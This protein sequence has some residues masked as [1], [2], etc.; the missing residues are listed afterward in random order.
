MQK[1][2]IV[3][4]TMWRAE[5]IVENIANYIQCDAVSSVV[6]ID[7]D[8]VN[9]ELDK[10]PD[11]PKVRKINHGRNIFVN[12]AWNEGVSFC[13]EDILCI[14]NDDIV[15][16][17]KLFHIVSDLDLLSRQIDLVGLDLAVSGGTSL[18]RVAID[19]AVPLGRQFPGFG[20]CMFLPRA[21]FKAIPDSIKIWF[22]DDYLAHSNNNVYLLTTPLVKGKMSTTI[23][24][25]PP[26]S[27][28]H[29][30]IQ[31]D[32]VWARQNLLSPGST[33]QSPQQSTTTVDLGSG[34]VPR[35][36]FNADRI[37]GVDAHCSGEHILNCWIGFEPLPLADSSVEY[38]TAFDFLEHI[39]RFAMKEKPFNPFIDAMSEIW[40]ILKP[41]GLFFARTPAY[42]S[43]AAFQDPTHVNIITD[44]TVSYFASRP[45]ADGSLIDSWGPP[46]GKRY[47]FK[48]EFVLVKQW[49]DATHLCWHL[50]ATK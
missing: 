6:I 25:F 41:G 16:D 21:R 4:P 23:R 26:D 47:G 42:P 29:G 12:P 50:R 48:G 37:I 38:V 36:P 31:A 2:D 24:S 28:I 10:I 49:W 44:Q 35:N 45:C 46:L 43:A 17:N 1:I 15:V 8:P 5:G 40:R 20:A 9:S 27:E 22:G 34:S 30:V 19:R 11:T 7:N 14:V 39:P 33:M 18:S 3:I 32:I 13:Q